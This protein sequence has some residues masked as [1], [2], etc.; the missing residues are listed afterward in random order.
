MRR[1]IR[2]SRLKALPRVIMDFMKEHGLRI[3]RGQG[4]LRRRPERVVK[5]IIITF[6]MK[7]TG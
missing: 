4:F 7:E 3:G 6:R 1:D 5:Q 2:T